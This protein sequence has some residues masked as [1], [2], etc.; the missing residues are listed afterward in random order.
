MG[1]RRTNRSNQPLQLT[2]AAARRLLKLAGNPPTIEVAVQTV[3][4]QLLDG[5]PHPPTDLHA[6]GSR[7]DVTEFC[8]EDLPISGEVRRVKGS[9]VVA[10]AQDLPTGRRNFTIAH[11]LGHVILER[12]GP[13]CPR[14]GYEVERVCDMLATEMLM[15]HELFRSRCSPDLTV[16]QLYD[17]A[18]MFRTSLEATAH[19]CYEIH[20]V[21]M[22]EADASSIR[23]GSGVLRRSAHPHGDG[24]IRDAISRALTGHSGGA[25]VVVITGVWRG[26][27]RLE[28]SPTAQGDRAHLVIRPLRQSSLT[29]STNATGRSD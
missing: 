19:R 4:R 27:C 21:S 13:N 10:Y 18:H 22:A 6:V 25:T 3:V 1:V 7:L 14:S 24:E 5:L 8:P 23:W 12:T 28:W 11:E 17:L 26:Q 16:A 20:H 9:L 2:G 15:P 29:P